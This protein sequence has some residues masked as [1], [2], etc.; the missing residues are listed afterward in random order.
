MIPTQTLALA[1]LPAARTSDATVTSLKTPTANPS[2][3]TEVNKSLPKKR[4]LVNESSSEDEFLEPSL[5]PSELKNMD[6]QQQGIPNGPEHIAPVDVEISTKIFDTWSFGL[7]FGK[8]DTS[9]PSYAQGIQQKNL[10]NNKNIWKKVKEKESSLMKIS[11]A[12]NSHPLFTLNPSQVVKSSLLDK[13]SVLY[14]Q[15]TVKMFDECRQHLFKDYVEAKT[16]EVNKLSKQLTT[17]SITNTVRKELEPFFFALKENGNESLNPKFCT[18]VLAT[19]V[20]NI[21]NQ[22]RN[23]KD[24]YKLKEIKVRSELFLQYSDFSNVNPLFSILTDATGNIGEKTFERSEKKKRRI[25]RNTIQGGCGSYHS[26]ETKHESFSNPT[27]DQAKAKTQSKAQ[28]LAQTFTQQA[29]SPFKKGQ[30]SMFQKGKRKTKGGEGR[31]QKREENRKKIENKEIDEEFNIFN[32][33]FM[34][35][36]NIPIEIKNILSKGSYYTPIPNSHK[37]VS[38][39]SFDKAYEGIIQSLKKKNKLNPQAEKVSNLIR[40]QERSNLSIK[41]DLNHQQNIQDDKILS[42]FLTKHQLIVKE[43]D[44]NLGPV[45]CDL[46]WYKTEVE[47]HLF[48]NK[49]FKQVFCIPEQSIYN[50]LK[51]ILESHMRTT[52]FKKVLHDTRPNGKASNFHVL[53]KMHKT[54]L[55]TRPIQPCINN[56]VNAVAVWLNKYLYPYVAKAD[57]VFNGTLQGINKLENYTCYLKNPIIG[58]ADVTSLYTQLHIPSSI[59]LV[60]E[61]LREHGVVW[62]KDGSFIRE[63]LVFVLYNNYCTFGGK[64]F[65]Q[66]SGT[67]M[68]ISV[69]PTF[70]NITM[71]MI[72]KNKFPLH[73]ELSLYIR[74][75]DD[76]LWIAEREDEHKV[77][78]FFK[79]FNKHLTWTH[80]SGPTV[81]FL[82]LNVTLGISLEKHRKVDYSNYSKP[83]NPHLY[84]NPSSHQPEEYKFGWI[85]GEQI[86]LIRTCSSQNDYIKS[87][88]EFIENL[89]ARDFS[90]IK[91]KER[92]IY[93]YSHRHFFMQKKKGKPFKALCQ[94][95]KNTIGFTEIKKSLQKSVSPLINFGCLNQLTIPV[96]KGTYTTDICNTVNKKLLNSEPW[97]QSMSP[98]LSLTN[99]VNQDVCNEISETNVCNSVTNPVIM[100]EQTIN[101]LMELDHLG[102]AN[103]DL[104]SEISLDQDMEEMIENSVSYIENILYNVSSLTDLPSIIDENDIVDILENGY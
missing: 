57:W 90:D 47:K 68:G 77:L 40:D 76:V 22:S 93:E 39:T 53:I 81:V 78:N 45:I 12:G 32:I 91:I 55:K 86:R 74:L 95:I 52:E 26:S 30:E 60:M 50:K 9:L 23:L 34:K 85:T 43:A 18:S 72:E 25:R 94:P 38:L 97:V 58:T 27:K 80:E 84:T 62:S 2:H 8:L 88:A 3:T 17:Y 41:L 66:I 4:K 14:N 54:P 98:S 28:T 10:H 103:S 79:D 35:N 1:E 19:I 33:S 100:E 99:M 73:K 89:K 16:E 61:F 65:H 24:S 83:M 31:T 64:Y 20:N 101:D 42:N 75:L 36:N 29:K 104:Q 15:K 70:V 92:L 63:L 48:D 67:A 37:T 5:E 11:E 59:N 56:Q 102:S 87:L 6:V 7:D 96:L 71:A 44:K 13:T 46:S 49:T 21:V 51:T 82:D 69:A